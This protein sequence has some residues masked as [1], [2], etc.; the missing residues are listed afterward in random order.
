MV[1][2]ILVRTSL[3]HMDGQMPRCIYLETWVPLHK[4]LQRQTGIEEYLGQSSIHCVPVIW[5]TQNHL[6]LINWQILSY[7]YYFLWKP[8]SVLE[9]LEVVPFLMMQG[10][11]APWAHF[12][13][14]RRCSQLL[15]IFTGTTRSTLNSKGML[16][17][18]WTSTISTI[19]GCSF[20]L[21]SD[22]FQIPNIP[23]SV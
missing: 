6:T 4:W 17:G 22:S 21:T 13:G 1:L 3:G 11:V 19:C 16:W 12:R 5:C 2:H 14:K 18:E 9:S 7:W 10:L 20:A 23:V 15:W 8:K